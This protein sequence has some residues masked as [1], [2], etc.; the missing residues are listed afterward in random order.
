MRPFH[1]Y[2]LLPLACIVPATARGQAQASLDTIVVRTAKV[3]LHGLLWRPGG[4]G[5]FPAVLFNHG[6]YSS[7]DPL[8]SKDPDSIAAP[9]LRHGFEFLF[10][11]RRGVGLSRDQ[12]PAEGTLMDQARIAG[13]QAHRNAR[14]LQLLETESLAEARAGLAFLR[15]RPEVDLQ[16]VAV[17]GHS[18]G[19]SLTLL[20]AEG[21]T[22]LS[23]VV[24]FGAA[25][26]SWANSPA[27]QARLLGTVKQLTTPALF[28]HA[29]NDYSVA[30]GQDLAGEMHRLGRTSELRLYPAVGQSAADGHNFLYHVPSLWEAD[31]IAFLDAH[32]HS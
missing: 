6:S 28:L 16:R 31:V 25:A 18:F 26:G 20:L 11:F 30:P 8:P 9:F 5:P 17:V 29:A 12:G 4:P 10:L 23:A 24:V 32:R 2:S 21:D 3:V 22:T 15:L 1:L 19:G 13:G 27:L 14:Q 7:T